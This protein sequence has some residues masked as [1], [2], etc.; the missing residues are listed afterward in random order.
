MR[1]FLIDTG[2]ETFMIAPF[3]Q[4]YDLRNEPWGARK[5]AESGVSGSVF[6]GRS[7]SIDPVKGSRLSDAD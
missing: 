6:G 7:E 4:G 5:T 1:P 2:T 3:E